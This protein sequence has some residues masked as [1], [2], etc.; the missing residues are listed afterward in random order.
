MLDQIIRFALQNRLL[1]LAFAVGLLFHLF[2]DTVDCLWNFS[3]CHECYLNSRMYALRNWVRK[4]LGR[5]V[6]N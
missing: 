4:L 2:T 3:H 5:E 6:R 1:M